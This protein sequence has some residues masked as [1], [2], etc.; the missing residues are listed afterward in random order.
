[1]AIDSRPAPPAT[2]R[3]PEVV[4]SPRPL[5]QPR[6]L[7]GNR[8]PRR[9]PRVCIGTAS[10]GALCSGCVW[11]ISLAQA[12]VVG[13]DGQEDCWPRGPSLFY[14][15]VRAGVVRARVC[16]L[17]GLGPPWLGGLVGRTLCGSSMLSAENGR[18][19]RWLVRLQAERGEGHVYPVA[20]RLPAR[21]PPSFLEN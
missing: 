10:A 8:W 11:P 4:L 1:M 19:S 17:A 13:R 6:L 12:W 20:Q 21:P 5:P 7:R 16:G 14:P 18:A 9:L 3:D 2:P 15:Q